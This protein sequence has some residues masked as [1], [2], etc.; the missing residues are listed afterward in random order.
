MPDT[1]PCPHHP[2]C[3]LTAAPS[4]SGTPELW[5]A[6]LKQSGH[7]GHKQVVL[8]V[9]T[10]TGQLSGD[11]VSGAALRSLISGH[12]IIHYDTHGAR[13]MLDE[14]LRIHGLP[15]FSGPIH[16]IAPL[17]RRILLGGADTPLDIMEIP[18]LCGRAPSAPSRAQKKAPPVGRVLEMV[19][20]RLVRSRLEAGID[21]SKCRTAP[22]RRCD[23]VA[24]IESAAPRPVP[25]IPEMT[26]PPGG[27]RSDPWLPEEAQD[28]A[29]RYCEGA[30]LCEI[31]RLTGRS[32]R[33]VLARLQL[34][35]V[36]KRG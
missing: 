23:P 16:D 7:I 25:P 11:G 26:P 33:A 19:Y 21:I 1:P 24:H 15:R 18:K 29:H 34:D 36:V 10:Q 2:T 14:T 8:P 32:P 6:R 27:W 4:M 17:V 5:V 28:V 9:P 20:S 31:A 22:A 30:D 12:Q 35:D 13:D 3:L